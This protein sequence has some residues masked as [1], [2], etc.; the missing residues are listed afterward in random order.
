M[1][2]LT[3]D[4]FNAHLREFLFVLPAFENYGRVRGLYD[5]GPIGSR[6][7]NRILNTIRNIFVREYDFKELIT[8]ILTIP[9]VLENSGHV[10]RFKTKHLYCENCELLLEEKQKN[11]I[12]CNLEPTTHIIK[13]NLSSLF[14]VR[15]IFF[16]NYQ[17]KT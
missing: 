12:S 9:E 1:D 2:P 5:Y 7:F 17:N 10:E 15:S 14:N 6:I 16:R 8:S 4:Q 13:S 11:C 3:K